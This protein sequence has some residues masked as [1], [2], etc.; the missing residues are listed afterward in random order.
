MESKPKPFSMGMNV[1][2][3][4][5]IGFFAI[6][7]MGCGKSGNTIENPETPLAKPITGVDKIDAVMFDGDEED[8]YFEENGGEV[9]GENERRLV[10]APKTFSG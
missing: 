10:M 3:A 2:L 7:W 1:C 8:H 6:S 9:A 4:A 5:L